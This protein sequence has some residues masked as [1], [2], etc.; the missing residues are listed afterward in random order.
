MDF[1]RR[2]RRATAC[3]CTV[4]RRYGVLWAYDYE[5]EGIRLTGDTTAYIRGDKTIGFHFCKVCA[6]VAYW[7]AL[8]PDKKGRRRVVVNLRL[9]E[10]DDEAS[11]P[12][13][14]L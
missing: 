14:P 5:G 12:V 10:P 11:I 3:N 2:S 7:R 4:C 1:R 13:G 6:C 8:E 9:A